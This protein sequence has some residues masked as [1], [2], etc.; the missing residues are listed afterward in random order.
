MC[1]LPQ[2][3]FSMNNQLWKVLELGTNSKAIGT[4]AV[5]NLERLMFTMFRVKGF[6]FSLYLARI[7]FR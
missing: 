2:A 3:S 1:E 5:R 7:Y 6:S 4:T